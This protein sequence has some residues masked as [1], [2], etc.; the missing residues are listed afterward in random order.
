MRRQLRRLAEDES[1]RRGRIISLNDLVV[2]AVADLLERQ[3]R[4]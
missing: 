4:A 3:G 2:E 1:D